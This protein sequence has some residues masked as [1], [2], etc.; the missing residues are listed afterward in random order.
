MIALSTTTFLIVFAVALV[1]FGLVV[2]FKFYFENK[3]R[4]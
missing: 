3:K 1:L 2:G 4:S